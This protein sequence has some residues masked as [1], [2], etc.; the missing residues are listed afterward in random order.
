MPE[1]PPMRPHP[2]AGVVRFPCALGC[3]WKHTEDPCA[4]DIDTISLP[5]SAST[6]EISRIFGERSER[7]AAALRERVE[8]AVRG[9]F[10][11]AHVGQEPPERAVW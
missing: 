11:D 3:G 6:E 9:H 8:S 1:L 5:L 2:G 4:D 10:A 7:R